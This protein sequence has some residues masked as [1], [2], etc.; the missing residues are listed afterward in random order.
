MR[1][2]KKKQFKSR[3]VSEDTSD[4]GTDLYCSEGEGSRVSET[5]RMGSWIENPCHR[6]RGKQKEIFSVPVLVWVELKKIFSCS[7]SPRS[8]V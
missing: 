6:A 5:Y 3:A 8:G 4:A 7:L 2:G 1:L